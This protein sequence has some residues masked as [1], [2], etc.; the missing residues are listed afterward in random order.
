MAHLFHGVKS[1]LP[2][3]KATDFSGFGDP[4]RDHWWIF[5]YEHDEYSQKHG[6]LCRKAMINHGFL[7][8]LFSDKPVWANQLAE[9]VS[10]Y[11]RF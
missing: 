11:G 8:V 4:N 2:L 7:R 3:G 10:V 6:I 1:E 5:W 9:Q